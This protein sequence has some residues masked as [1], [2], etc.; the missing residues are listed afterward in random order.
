MWLPT[1]L[2]K[3]QLER[4]ILSPVLLT[5]WAISTFASIFWARDLQQVF[6]GWPF[7]FWLGAQGLV[8]L[9]IFIVK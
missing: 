3:A 9:Y 5:I 7:N 8:I 6:M 4:Q 1:S 2:N